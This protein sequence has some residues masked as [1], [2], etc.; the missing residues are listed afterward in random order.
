MI[1][2][3]YCLGIIVLICLIA[4]FNTIKQICPKC[5]KKNFD[6]FENS[7]SLLICHEIEIYEISKRCDKCG[8]V[9][10]WYL[11]RTFD[12]EKSTDQYLTERPDF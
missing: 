9:E 2:I 12:H 8:H 10:T 1:I 5:G 11:K 7:K 3:W 6:N 4:R